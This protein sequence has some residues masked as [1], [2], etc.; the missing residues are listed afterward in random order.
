[1]DDLTEREV[2]L[3]ITILRLTDLYPSPTE[4][5]RQFDSVRKMLHDPDYDYTDQVKP[6]TGS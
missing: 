3:I 2:A 4:V 6:N 1:M 5:R